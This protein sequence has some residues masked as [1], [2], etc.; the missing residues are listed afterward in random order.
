MDHAASDSARR[1]VPDDAVGHCGLGFEI[2]DGSR[3]DLRGDG[4]ALGTEDG[5][6][7][8][9]RLSVD[10]EHCRGAGKKSHDGRHG[11]VPGGRVLHGGHRSF[12]VE[13]R[14]WGHFPHRRLRGD[15]RRLRRSGRRRHEL[16]DR[17]EELAPEGV[18][19]GLSLVDGIATCDD[20]TAHVGRVATVRRDRIGSC[21]R[22]LSS[23]RSLAGG[24][25]HDG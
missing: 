2:D 11:L 20:W 25:R 14:R 10:R 23:E 8:R 16:P 5:R 17:F 24:S 15:Y 22:Q 19:V 4:D 6:E 21:A 7:H 1:V 9:D 18:V 13:G 12:D 3:E